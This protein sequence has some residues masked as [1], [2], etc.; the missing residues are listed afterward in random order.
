MSI[1]TFLR[2]WKDR[3]I[4]DLRTRHF[5]LERAIYYIE[6]LK[7]EKNEVDNLTG[8]SVESLASWTKNIADNK[9]AVEFLVATKCL[10]MHIH[11][12]KQFVTLEPHGLEMYQNGILAS[13]YRQ[14]LRLRNNNRW[15]IGLNVVLAIG[16]IYSIYR[17]EMKKDATIGDIYRRL[18]RLE[19]KK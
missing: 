18:E 6:Y 19:Y 2:F 5:I 15:M 1:G 10:K 14:Q 11:K 8:I 17:D 16:V 4:R 9:R 3:Y 12:G 7:G 13:E